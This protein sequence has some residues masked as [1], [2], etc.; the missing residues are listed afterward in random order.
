MLM[1]KLLKNWQR[2]HEYNKFLHRLH[3]SEAQEIKE[4]YTVMIFCAIFLA[5]ILL[6]LQ[7]VLSMYILNKMELQQLIEFI[8]TAGISL[9][10]NDGEI[11]DFKIGEQ[12]HDS[13]RYIQNNDR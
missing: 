13:R 4:L 10:I 11:Q 3:K 2:R 7:E 1:N 12:L 5:Y 8:N 9:I 6:H